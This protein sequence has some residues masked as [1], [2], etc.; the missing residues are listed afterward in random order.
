MRF[1]ESLTRVV[2]PARVGS[3]CKH[4]T[5][6]DGR[7][8]DCGRLQAP[9]MASVRPPCGPGD[10]VRTP[11]S[12]GAKGGSIDRLVASG[13]AGL[14]RRKSFGKEPVWHFLISWRKERNSS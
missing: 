4:A 7:P 12:L 13:S 8:T 3:G 9:L 11:E 10:P 5:C 1:W 6:A 2:P 14:L